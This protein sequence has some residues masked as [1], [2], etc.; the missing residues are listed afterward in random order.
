[1]NT[2]NHTQP[3]YRYNKRI[4]VTAKTSFLA[5][6]LSAVMYSPI[7]LGA[8]TGTCKT[9]QDV[10]DLPANHWCEVFDSKARKVEKPASEWD[11]FAAGS[12]AKYDSY[13]GSTGFKAIMDNWSSAAFDTK[14]DRLI[15]FGGGHNGYGGNEI[16]AFS[17]RTLQWSRLTDPTPINIA[18]ETQYSY[19]IDSL[20]VP[21]ARHT[22]GGLEYMAGY[23]KLFVFDGI[24]F[25]PVGSSV[26]GAWTF[27]LAA[28]Q[29]NPPA[30]N[31]QF[32]TMRTNSVIGGMEHGEPLFGVESF[33]VYDPISKLIL[34]QKHSGPAGLFTYD[35]TAP[36][37]RQENSEAAHI[38]GFGTVDTKR[39][40]YVL[41]SP[42]AHNSSGTEVRIGKAR[43]TQLDRNSGGVL[44]YKIVSTTGGQNIEAGND[45]GVAYDSQVDRIVAYRG[46]T[47]VY[48]FNTETYAWQTQSA[49]I[50]NNATPNTPTAQGGIY[51]RFR[52]SPQL[53]VYVFVN[54]V[55]QNVFLYRLGQPAVLPSPPQNVTAH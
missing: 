33:A 40:I 25:Y 15:V 29:N 10:K 14:R 22:Y 12:S 27:D 8:Y 43:I 1:M 21:I 37:W 24:K 5:W 9:F 45:P 34:F 17:L 44:D 35:D 13:Q 36:Q 50:S 39:H 41:F 19:V 31:A 3:A 48:L 32:W 4:Q 18:V 47:V 54:S 52:Y 26:P 55:D 49:A 11:D 30:G 46:G 6:L 23:D 28:A 42:V 38:D 51:G 53:G 20:E 2:S 16:L 7:A